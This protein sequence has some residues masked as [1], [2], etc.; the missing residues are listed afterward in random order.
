MPTAIRKILIYYSDYFIYI[1][2]LTVFLIFRGTAILEFSFA[3]LYD[4]FSVCTIITDFLFFEYKCTI[5]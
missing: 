2:C 1:E 5:A 4:I 3:E